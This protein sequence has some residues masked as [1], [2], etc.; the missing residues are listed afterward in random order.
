MSTGGTDIGDWQGR[1]AEINR[2][3][4]GEWQKFIS[5]YEGQKLEIF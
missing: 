1:A 2:A 5:P 3:R 4:N